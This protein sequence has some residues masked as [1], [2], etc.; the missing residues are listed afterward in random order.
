MRRPTQTCSADTRPGQTHALEGS[1]E[2]QRAGLGRSS[3]GPLSAPAQ[4]LHPGLG[5]ISVPADVCGPCAGSSL[6][7]LVNDYYDPVT[8]IPRGHLLRDV[9]AINCKRAWGRGLTKCSW[10]IRQ[11]FDFAD[12]VV[13]GGGGAGRAVE[14]ETR[15]EEPTCEKVVLLKVRSRGTPGVPETLARGLRIKRTSILILRHYSLVLVSFPCDCTMEFS[16]FAPYHNRLNAETVN[17]I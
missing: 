3:R 1:A 14:K 12:I 11:D 16:S 8:L 4:R 5:S 7:S 9:P 17:N 15:C 13:C 6:Q 10:K 2:T